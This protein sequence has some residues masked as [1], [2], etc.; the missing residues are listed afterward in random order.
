MTSII[1]TAKFKGENSVNY[2]HGESYLLR[3]STEKNNAI[4]VQQLIEKV[5]SQQKIDYVVVMGSL[6]KYDSIVTFLYLWEE[7]TSY[8]SIDVDHSL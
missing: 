8:P 2:M 5:E 6:I 3:V 4:V 7:V 1:V